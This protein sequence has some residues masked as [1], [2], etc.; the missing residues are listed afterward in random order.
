[1]ALL[2][3][4]VMYVFLVAVG[5]HGMDR[6]NIFS[7]KWTQASRGTD[8]SIS[9]IEEAN[10]MMNEYDVPGWMDVMIGHSHIKYI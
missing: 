1:M 7:L 5:H 10:R 3:F 2:A 8:S 4:V 9:C 6:E